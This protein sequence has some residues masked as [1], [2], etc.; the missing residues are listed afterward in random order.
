MTLGSVDPSSPIAAV[1]K[2]PQREAESLVGRCLEAGINFFD[3]ADAYSNGQTEA[4]LGQALGLRRKDIVIATKIG[5][6]TVKP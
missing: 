2:T 3:T 4:I 5:F 1:A 6:R